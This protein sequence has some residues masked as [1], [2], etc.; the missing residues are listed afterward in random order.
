[1]D[2]EVIMLEMEVDSVRRQLKQMSE[3]G[4]ELICVT[5]LGKN[6]TGTWAFFKKPD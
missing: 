1:M 5:H 3:D 6:M 2:H 4:W